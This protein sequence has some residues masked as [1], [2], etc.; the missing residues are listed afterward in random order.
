MSTETTPVPEPAPG[1][2]EQTGTPGLAAEQ[3][4]GTAP[5]AQ[6]ADDS[7][8]ATELPPIPPVPPVPPLST[9]GQFTPGAGYAHTY[10][11]GQPTP[12]QVHPAAAPAPVQ[13]AARKP[14]PRTSPI[15]WGA[16]ILVF[17][18]YVAVRAA[19]GSIDVT[20]WLITTILG[21]GTLLLVVGVAVLVRTSRDK[22]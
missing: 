12:P 7:A 19:G 21:L 6:L 13:T 1:D 22:N 2:A 18:A 15:V 10:P 3:P 8:P 9:T 4:G 16:L 17:C 11:S 5:A 20:T 14:R